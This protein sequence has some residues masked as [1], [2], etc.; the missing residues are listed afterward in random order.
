MKKDSEK[1]LSII[2]EYKERPNKDLIFVMDYI[3]N[4]FE[5]TKESVIKLTNHLD[6]LEKTYNMILQEYNIRTKN[7]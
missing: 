2:N 4:D 5:L 6:K 3:K 1:A 7:E